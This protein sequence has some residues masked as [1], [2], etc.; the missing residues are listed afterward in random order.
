M[1]IYKD[2]VCTICGEYFSPTTGSA[3]ICSKKECYILNR[4]VKEKKRYILKKEKLKKVCPFCSAGFVT[5]DTKRK[6]CFNV[7]CAARAIYEKNYRSDQ[8]RRGTRTEY[9]KNR[10]EDNKEYILSYKKLKYRED[11]KDRGVKEGHSTSR[12]SLEEVKSRFLTRGYIIADEGAYQHSHSEIDVICPEGHVWKVSCH[13]FTSGQSCSECQ[14][15]L[16]Q[17]RPEKELCD[18][19]K[20]KK[21]LL[22]ERDKTIIQP[23][24]LDLYFP[25]KKVAVEY[26]GLYWHGEKVGKDKKHLRNKLDL[27]K[28]QGIRLITIFEDEYLN[29]PEIVKSRLCNALGLVKT[30]LY[31]RKCQVSV[32]TSKEANKFFEENHLQGKSPTKIA[33]GL[34]YEKELVQVLSLGDLS[35]AHAG[36]GHRFIELKR[37]ASSPNITIVG[38]A[39]RLFSAAKKWATENEYSHIKSY[40]DMRWAN[41]FNVVYDALKFELITET[42][43]TP[44]YFRGQVRYRNQTLRKTPEERLT[45]KTEWELRQEQG[46]DRIWDCGHRTYLYTL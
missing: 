42:K 8:K 11:N 37:L 35:R 6:Y 2:K 29:R 46:Y 25:E 45:G 12:L 28:V 32:L 19:F 33:W 44:H 21:I 5:R 17:S 20:D 24:E 13:R 23:Y 10:Y 15:G 40:C 3:I 30:R 18:Y 14:K 22:V 36:K 7:Q 26:C 38:G 39:S 34:F 43:Y 9:T 27:C 41:L 4:R 16:F 31:A 1:A